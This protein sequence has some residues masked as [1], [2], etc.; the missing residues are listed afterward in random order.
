MNTLIDLSPY[1]GKTV[2]VTGSSGYL[3]NQLVH[4]LSQVACTVT[5]V[6]RSGAVL[7]LVQGVC[8]LND[9]IG[10]LNQLVFWEP[11]IP[12]ADVIFHFAGRADLLKANQDP[13]DDLQYNVLPLLT[14]LEACRRVGRVPVVI[15]ASTVSVY[16]SQERL[17]VNE[18]TP[19]QPRSIYDL[20]K[21][22]SE[23]YLQYYAEQGF[24]HGA[25]LRLSN[26]YGPDVRAGSQAHSV[27]NRFIHQGLTAEPLTVYE[28][29]TATRDYIYVDDV[30]SAFLQAGIHGKTLRGPVLNVASGQAYSTTDVAQKV[31]DAL[32]QDL[33]RQVTVH[34][35]AAPETMRQGALRHLAVDISAI[36]QALS[37]QPK[38]N[39]EKGIALTLAA[40]R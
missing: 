37:W 18:Q 11:I 6:A 26:V 5:R 7:S 23:H 38:I 2:V 34:R 9:V 32:T 16:G 12:F 30:A 8:R 36:T 33:G 31:A 17:P 27:I 28:P 1:R 19:I 20:H 35:Q 15:L 24:I 3:A 21:Y 29:G 4:Q 39:L 25:A 10:D 14:V 40:L 22:Q 13:L